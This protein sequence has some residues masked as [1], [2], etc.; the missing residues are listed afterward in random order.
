MKVYLGDSPIQLI[1]KRPK[2][3]QKLALKPKL[4]GVYNTRKDFG[5]VAKEKGYLFVSTLPNVKTH[6]CSAQVYELETLL[7]EKGIEATICH[8]SSDGKSSWS[9]V[10]KLHPGLK[11]LGFTLQEADK[12]TVLTFKESL[13]VGV[14]NSHRLAHGLFAYKD[15]K[16]IGSLIP[17]QQYGSPNIKKF[18]SKI[19]IT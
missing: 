18:L 16:L 12:E 9:E 1:G 11:C 6:A 13:G 15:G 14:S 4:P 7:A 8:I 5:S 17:K 3:G 10:K 19:K 2:P